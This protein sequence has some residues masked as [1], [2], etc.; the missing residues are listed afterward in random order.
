ML[1][2]N[3]KAGDKMLARNSLILVAALGLF[4]LVGCKSTG[5]EHGGAMTM[6]TVTIVITTS[7]G[8]IEVELW[9]EKAPKTVASF[10]SYVDDGFFN[11][12]ILFNTRLFISASDM[13]I[14]SQI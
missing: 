6:E 8:D 10:L 7:K 9:G 4:A 11:N 5:E 12:T 1:V 3:A 13:Y 2:A 14:H